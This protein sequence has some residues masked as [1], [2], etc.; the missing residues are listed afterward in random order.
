MTLTINYEFN[1][2]NILQ[3]RNEN[4]KHIFLPDAE[5]QFKVPS[6]TIHPSIETSHFQVNHSC[7]SHYPSGNLKIFTEVE[8]HRWNCRLDDGNSVYQA[9][10]YVIH[11]PHGSELDLCL[12]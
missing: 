3:L 7:N 6:W 10:L 4:T 2:T 12:G 8:N 1:K 5:I 9:E 11:I